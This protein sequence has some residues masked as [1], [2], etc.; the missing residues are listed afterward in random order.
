[1]FV[2]IH[3]ISH[4]RYYTFHGHVRDLLKHLPARFYH[5]IQM[6]V[7]NA[8]NAFNTPYLKDVQKD[9]IAF[10]T[11]FRQPVMLR[12]KTNRPWRVGN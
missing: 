9:D 8:D 4:V 7:D 12:N 5:L 1:M 6:N 10:M 2:A 3:Q 11:V